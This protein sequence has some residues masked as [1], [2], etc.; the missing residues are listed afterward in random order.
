MTANDNSIL[1]L[2]RGQYAS[3]SHSAVLPSTGRSIHLVRPRLGYALLKTA[4]LFSTAT[5]VR[6][7]TGRWPGIACW[8]FAVLAV[9]A[10]T[11]HDLPERT[12]ERAIQ[13]TVFHDHVEIIYDFGFNPRTVRELYLEDVPPGTADERL[14][15]DELA[16]AEAFLARQSQRI[17]QG[18][19]VLL[20]GKRCPLKTLSHE[21]TYQHHLQFRCWLSYA[22]P[23]RQG[24]A[25]LEVRDEGFPGWPGYYRVAVRGKPPSLIERT[26][27]A[28]IIVRAERVAV[29]GLG[30]WASSFPHAEALL[31]SV[32]DGADSADR[33]VQQAVDVVGQQQS[34]QQAT[35]ERQTQGNTDVKASE[36]P[37]ENV[38]TTALPSQ[39]LRESVAS[40]LRLGWWVVVFV[41]AVATILSWYF[42]SKD[43]S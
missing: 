24:R 3:R 36:I 6:K 32:M 22:L 25:R 33:S 41:A 16:L 35:S 11:A 7:T 5:F 18:L 2:R 8:V 14:L 40:G 4:V 10:I 38:P 19:L 12:L 42:I 1:F 13:V 37:R 31:S 39:D 34:P 29:E 17:P 21:V 9:T 15:S 26:N 30:R 27:A 28:P 43:R 20:D 23:P